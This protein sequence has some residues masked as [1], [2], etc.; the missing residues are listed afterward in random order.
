MPNL[1]RKFDKLKEKVEKLEKEDLA[2]CTSIAK[3]LARLDASRNA[4]QK[5]L[6]RSAGPAM[7]L[8]FQ[9]SAVARA[10]VS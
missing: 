3:K 2:L 6:H 8:G 10:S 9:F 5:S 1:T 7:S 4:L